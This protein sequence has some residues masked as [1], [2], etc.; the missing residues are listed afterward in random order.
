MT[1]SEPEP[2]S[3]LT[4]P[5]V[6]RLTEFDATLHDGRVV[7][8]RAIR[9]SDEAELLQAFDRLS[10]EARYMRFMRAVREPDVKRLHKTLAS[11]PQSGD[12]IVA[13]IPADDGIDIVGSAT[14]IIVSDSTTCEF[15]ISVA[16]DFGGAGL[17][18][19]LMKAL[20]ATARQR[21]LKEME[22]FILAQNQPMLRLA[23]RMGFKFSRDPDDATVRH[24]RLLLDQA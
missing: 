13:T 18:S 15:A 6:H 4:V 9:E 1:D 23:E 3:E 21:G 20:I 12:A 5:S 7:H 10:A 19:T 11:F 24:C 22:G 17:G 2:S 8:L 16:G 14:F